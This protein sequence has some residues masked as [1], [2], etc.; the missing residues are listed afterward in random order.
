MA[1]FIR[2]V[3][4]F[5]NNDHIIQEGTV[6]NQHENRPQLR[7]GEHFSGMCPGSAPTVTSLCI[8]RKHHTHAKLARP[9][10]Q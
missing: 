7:H 8:E 2:H 5:A 6:L 10:A 4:C 1:F 9:G 3:C